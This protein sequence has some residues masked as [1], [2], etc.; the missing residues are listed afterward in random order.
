MMLRSSSVEPAVETAIMMISGESPRV[1]DVSANKLASSHGPSQAATCN[2]G[3]NILRQTQ[4]THGGSLVNRYRKAER[5]EAKRLV[6]A[7]W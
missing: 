5:R 7:C 1:T 4:V 3:T 6:T 2:I